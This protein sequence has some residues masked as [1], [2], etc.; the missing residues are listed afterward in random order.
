[1]AQQTIGVVEIQEDEGRIQAIVRGAPSSEHARLVEGLQKAIA[2]LQSQ[3]HDP[4]QGSEVIT[5]R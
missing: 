3:S 4:E 1:M 5:V 2:F